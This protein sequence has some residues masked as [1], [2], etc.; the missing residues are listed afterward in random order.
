MPPVST[1]DP[2]EILG[3]SSA[4]W[5]STCFEIAMSEYRTQEGPATRSNERLAA[6]IHG[7]HSKCN[8]DELSDVL[9]VASHDLPDPARI[10]S[11]RRRHT[12]ATELLSAGMSLVGV[13]RLL[14]HRDHRM[15]LRYAAVTPE[16]VAEE[17]QNTLA[18]LETKYRLPT[19][20]PRRRGSR[21]C[22]TRTSSWTTSPGGFASMLRRLVRPATCS[23]HRAAQA[24][25]PEREASDGEGGPAAWYE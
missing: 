20:L 10:T 7:N 2:C 6:V 22:P 19:P 25:R 15:T 18:K 4:R 23:A 13:M 5:N 12:L 9:E 14:G 3:P 24:G 1:R 21:T 8:W 11:H 17:Y 16:I